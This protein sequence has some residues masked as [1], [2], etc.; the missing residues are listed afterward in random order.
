MGLIQYLVL[1]VRLVV[2]VFLF[3][4]WI[5]LLILFAITLLRALIIQAAI[6]G[7]LAYVVIHLRRLIRQDAT[8]SD[9]IP[10][11]VPPKPKKQIRRSAYLPPPRADD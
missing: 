9:L 2:C 10:S 5:V 8:W 1:L 3:L 4:V 6:A 11:P 7:V